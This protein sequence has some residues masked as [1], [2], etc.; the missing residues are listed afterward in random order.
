MTVARDR[1]SRAGA[2]PTGDF[3]GTFDFATL[4]KMNK[5][6]AWQTE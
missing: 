1:K 4:T 2:R 5:W 6:L 3:R